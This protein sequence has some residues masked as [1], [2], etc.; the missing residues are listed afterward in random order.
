MYNFVFNFQLINKLR[1]SYLIILHSITCTTVIL[2]KKK[3]PSP[4]LPHLHNFLEH[5]TYYNFFSGKNAFLFGQTLLWMLYIA[6][7]GLRTNVNDNKMIFLECKQMNGIVVVYRQTARTGQKCTRVPIGVFLRLTK[8]NRVTVL[9]N[10]VGF[11]IL[12]R[13]MV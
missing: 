2:G 4:N 10:Q 9:Y 5:L 13:T 11:M 7:V 3:K 8:C 1:S 12:I 6:I